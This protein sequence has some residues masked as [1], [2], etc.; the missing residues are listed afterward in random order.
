MKRFLKKFAIA[1]ALLFFSFWLYLYLNY[2]TPILM[3][4]SFDKNKVE[5][6][7]AVDPA[8]FYRQMEFIKKSGYRVISLDDYCQMLKANQKIPKNLM[9]ITIDDGY[10]DNLAA[11]KTLREFNFPATIFLVVDKIGRSE[12]LSKKDINAF[13]KNTKVN[14]GS[15]TLT[16][17]D[18]PKIDNAQL[19][20]EILDSKSKLTELFSTKVKTFAYPGGAFDERAMK[21]VESSDYLCACATNRGF[22]KN[23]NRFALR[24]IKVTDR[25]SNFT[26]WSKLSG[27]YNIFKK[28][29]KPY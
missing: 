8:N 9:A 5:N 13:L 21:E 15:H 4:H 6:Y 29:K 23:L 11:I 7:A 14:I 3:Y 16:H 1:L 17:P 20:K 18:L 10:K 24:R 2:T 12:Y 27:F 19:K 28:P 25:D 26:L 22:S